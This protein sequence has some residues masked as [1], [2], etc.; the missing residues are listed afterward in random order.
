M[1]NKGKNPYYEEYLFE[2]LIGNCEIAIND[3]KAPI[4]NYY[5]EKFNAINLLI[6][7]YFV[8]DNLLNEFFKKDK[9]SYKL[10]RKGIEAILNYSLE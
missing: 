1:Q 5:S 9:D 4:L 2:D 7:L 3:K 6:N 8:S 10:N